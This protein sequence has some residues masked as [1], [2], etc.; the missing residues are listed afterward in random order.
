MSN[1]VEP[2]ADVGVIVG[3]FQVSELHRGHCDLID[4]VIEKHKKVI[5]LLGVSPLANSMTNPLDFEARKQ[6][7]LSQYPSVNVLYVK[8]QGTD[9][10]WS[11]SVDATINDLRGPTQTVLLYGSRDS[12]IG[13]YSGMFDTFSLPRSRSL[14]GTQVREEIGRES[15]DSADWRAGVIWASRNRFPVSYVCVDIAIFNRDF[16]QIL[17]GRKQNEK[18]WRLPG[19]F[20]DPGS[21]SI[22]DDAVREAMEETHCKVNGISYIGSFKV[23]DWRYRNEPD[24]LK[25]A[26]FYGWTDDLGMA[27]DDLAEVDWQPVGDVEPTAQSYLYAPHRNLVTRALLATEGFRKVTHE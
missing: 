7:I 27:D 9:E 16:S 11:K 23:E 13:A 26:L 25:T 2:T 20:T 14:S 21:V 6:M 17:L 12:F 15:R 22:E 8:D 1:F 10:V 19:G 3:R 5:I 18:T 4:S 24:G